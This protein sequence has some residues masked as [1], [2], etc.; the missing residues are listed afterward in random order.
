MSKQFHLDKIFKSLADSKRREIFH[1]LM[2]STT[3]LTLSQITEKFDISR[4]GVTKHVELLRDAGL[5]KVKNDGRQRFC[6][7]DPV[8]LTELKD[9]LA[10]Y[11]KFWDK[12]LNNLSKFLDT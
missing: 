3:A 8:P 11:D 10:F 4:Q 7:V 6:E 12:K 9:W 1:L 5:V 2:I